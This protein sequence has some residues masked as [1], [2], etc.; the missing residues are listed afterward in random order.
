MLRSGFSNEPGFITF[1]AS[2]AVRPAVFVCLLGGAVYLSS[3]FCR[4]KTTFRLLNRFTVTAVPLWLLSSSE[5][6]CG[7]TTWTAMDAQAA[8]SAP[9]VVAI[10]PDV[11]GLRDRESWFRDINRCACGDVPFS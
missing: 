5:T 10:A 7:R 8:T 1:M 2:R 9:D 4:E 3:S 6:I 11:S